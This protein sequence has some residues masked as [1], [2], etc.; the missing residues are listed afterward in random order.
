MIF[1]KGKISGVYIIEPEK[2][3][4]ERGFFSRIFDS[5]IFKELGLVSNFVQHSVSY[6]KKKG[7]LRGLHYQIHPF[8]ET[9]IV[10]CSSGKIFDVLVDLRPSSTTYK[11]W[12]AIELTSDNLLIIYIPEGIAHGFQTLDDNTSVDYKI[13]QIFKPEFS[14]GIRWN[15]NTFQIPWPMKPTIISKKDLSYVD[16]TD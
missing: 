6:N 8:S 10:S 1:T 9:K 7:T 3:E 4:D 12:D 14:Q 15:D 5:D 13:S 16:F 11:Q 2:L